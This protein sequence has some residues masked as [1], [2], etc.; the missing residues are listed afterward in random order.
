MGFLPPARLRFRPG[1]GSR[2]RLPARLILQYQRAAQRFPTAR[3]GFLPPARL[4]FRPRRGIR[5]RL[6]AR[7]ILQHQRAGQRFPAARMGFLPPV[8]LPLRRRA[9]LLQVL[10]ASRAVRPP[11]QGG[12]LAPANQTVRRLVRL[13][14]LFPRRRQPAFPGRWLKAS[15]AVRL[16]RLLR[17]RMIS[18]VLLVFCWWQRLRRRLASNRELHL[19]ALR[20]AGFRPSSNLE[21]LVPPRLHWG[22][23]RLPSTNLEYR[24]AVRPAVPLGT[25]KRG[26][27]FLLPTSSLVSQPR[28]GWKKAGEWAGWEMLRLAAASR[29]VHRP[30]WPSA[31]RCG[32]LRRRFLRRSANPGFHPIVLGPVH[33]AAVHRTN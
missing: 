11:A 6:P 26:K 4:R 33:L 14:S 13:P 9:V 28:W 15:R 20:R 10:R 24:R 18:G 32:R 7:L 22:R 17:L 8:R 30:C 31:P 19:L 21:F 23:L 12:C 3:M 16:V 27:L 5:R 29:G 1:R 25:R 2:R